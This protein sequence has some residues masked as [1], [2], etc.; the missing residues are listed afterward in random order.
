LIARAASA[1]AVSVAISSSL[2]LKPSLQILW[3]NRPSLT[4][5]PL[6][7][8]GGEPLGQ[9]VTTPLE[10]TDMLFRLTLVVKL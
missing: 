10:K 7:T 3:R 6:F 8:T 4:E 9:N 2:A 5:V 1:L